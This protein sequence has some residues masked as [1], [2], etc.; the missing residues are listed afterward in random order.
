LD[1]QERAGKRAAGIQSLLATAALIDS[2]RPR[3]YARP[4]RNL[5]PASTASL[6]RSCHSARA[7]THSIRGNQVERLLAYAMGHLPL[8]HLCEEEAA[9]R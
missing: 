5:H 9:C 3:G 8:E 6:T 7:I 4:S 2:I 1:A